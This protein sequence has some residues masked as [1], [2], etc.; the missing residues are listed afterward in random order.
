MQLG[1][2][3]LANGRVCATILG[4]DAVAIARPSLKSFARVDLYLD[5]DYVDS[6]ET[7]RLRVGD[8]D[9]LAVRC[10]ARLLSRDNGG[11]CATCGTSLPY[12]R[13]GESEFLDIDNLD[14]VNGRFFC[15]GGC[16]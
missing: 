1:K 16:L 6:M 14:M 11:Q 9:S 3:Q 13:V 8:L 7:D 12:K 5:G 4:F 15:K 2:W 10:A